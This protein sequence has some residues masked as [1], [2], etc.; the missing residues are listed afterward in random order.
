MD[1]LKIT[2]GIITTMQ[3]C[4]NVH[5][6]IE[7]IK[8]QNIPKD[9]YEIIIVGGCDISDDDNIRKIPFDEGQRNMWITRKKNIITQEANNDIIVYLHDYLSLSSDWY[10]EFLKFGIDWDICMNRIVNPN[11]ERILDWMGLPDDRVYGNVMMPYEYG[12]SDGMYIPGYYWISKKSVMV[13]FPLNEDFIWGE[14]EDIEWSKRVIGGFP[15]PWLKNNESLKNG[16]IAIKKHKYVVNSKSVI[17]ALKHK[18]FNSN[19]SSKYDMH[20]GN[21]SRP[22]ESI[23]EN[24]EYL[25]YRL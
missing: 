19:F 23:P 1:E 9:D 24:Y 6:I 25:K 12:G 2:F 14:G 17:V 3:T 13:N 22:M 15:P 20:S 10:Q 5:K 8:L 18:G 7:S 4:G 21:E 11:G 16:S